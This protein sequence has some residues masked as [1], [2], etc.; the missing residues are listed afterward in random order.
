MSYTEL[1]LTDRVTI[2]ICLSKG[3]SLQAI[4]RCLDRSPSTISREVR[5][6]SDS[7]DG[8]RAE[9][10]QAARLKHWLYCRPK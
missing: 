10:A 4:A 9:R 2:Q 8:Y 3:L 1:N 7:G 6:N 5:R